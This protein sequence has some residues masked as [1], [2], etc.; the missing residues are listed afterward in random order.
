MG[1]LI[2]LH[3]KFLIIFVINQKR[4]NKL[5]APTLAF[6]ARANVQLIAS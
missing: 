1:L 4:F 3:E 2:S 5:N 6:V